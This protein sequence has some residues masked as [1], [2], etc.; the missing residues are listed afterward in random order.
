MR[1]VFISDTHQQ[2]DQIPL[3]GGTLVHAGD[4][5]FHGTVEEVAKETRWLKAIRVSGGFEEAVFVPG[6]HDWLAETDPA[7]MRNLVEEAGWRY[8]DHRPA[9]IG[10]FRFFGSGYTPRFYDWAL[11]VER[12]PALARLWAQIPDDTQILVTH[13]PPHGHLDEVNRPA[14]EMDAEDFGAFGRGDYKRCHKRTH[15]GCADL[16]QRIQS[17]KD[18]KVHAFGHVHEPGIE[19]GA[20]GVT[21]INA[22]TCDQSYKAVHKPI[23]LDI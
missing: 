17:L 9:V 23:V 8:L 3:G 6:N 12:G 5:T 2:H 15:V 22:S 16:A 18:L 14:G 11:N 20:N 7:M 10:G 19:V 1:L 21:Y 4:L 13:G